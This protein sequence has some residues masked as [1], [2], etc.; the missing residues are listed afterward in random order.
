MPKLDLYTGV[1]VTLM[2][3]IGIIL[4][5]TKMRREQRKFAAKHFNKLRALRSNHRNRKAA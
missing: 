5:I 1:V 4:G 3:L 2:F